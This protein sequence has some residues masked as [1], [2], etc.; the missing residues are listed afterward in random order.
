ME[1]RKRGKKKLTTFGRM[2]I[3]AVVGVFFIVGCIGVA[4]WY[5]FTAAGPSTSQQRNDKIL[6]DVEGVSKSHKTRSGQKD[7]ADP[8][9]AEFVDASSEK[10]GRWYGLCKKQS[11]QSIEDFRRTVENDPAL[12]VYYAGFHWEDA[13]IGSLKEDVI[14]YVAHRKG[15][16]IQP[17]TKPIKLPKGDQ[18]IT[19]GERTAR[20]YCCNDI[21]LAPSAGE[22]P[23]TKIDPGEYAPFA[24]ARNTDPGRTNPPIFPP[25]EDSPLGTPTHSLP[26]DPPPP[27][28]V[29]EPGTLTLM[30]GGLLFLAAFGRKRKS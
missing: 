16:L 14:A 20:T 25:G 7:S 15:D 12:S 21:D 27:A 6:T 13:K 11:I 5:F 4:G 24:P 29:P 23:P 22:E 26:K 30:G 1:E 17:T 28:V 9:L 19:D 10:N 8:E 3:R 18:Y 2:L